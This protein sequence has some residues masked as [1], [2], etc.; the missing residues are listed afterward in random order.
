MTLNEIREPPPERLVRLTKAEEHLYDLG[1]MV[2]RPEQLKKRYAA[3]GGNG[4]GGKDTVDESAMDKAMAAALA[5]P[6]PTAG[7]AG[8]P[9]ESASRFIKGWWFKDDAASA[10]TAK[11]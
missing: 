2:L 9:E 5:V 3:E 7:A 1:G 8:K 10:P 4:D 11:R 6:I